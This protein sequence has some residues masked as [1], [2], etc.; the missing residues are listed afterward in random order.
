VL[1]AEVGIGELFASPSAAAVAELITQ[2]TGG[3][4]Q[5][6]TA[7][8]RPQ[9]LPLSFGQQRMWVLNQLEGVGQGAAYN[10]PMV[11][12]IVGD[13]DVAALE[14]ALGDVAER[15]ESLRTVFLDVEGVAYQ[16]VLRGVA[17]RPV[18]AVVQA[19]EEELPGM[20]AAYTGRGFDLSMELPW[21]V[22]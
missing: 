2:L 15:H 20:V 10:M 12:R 3:V 6:L 9:R 19:R 18:L 11:L 7:R 17:G 21:R 1:G 22:W 16:Q 14:A 13:L 8:P 4:R 5:A